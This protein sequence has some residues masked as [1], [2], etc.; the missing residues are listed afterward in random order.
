MYE[1]GIRVP[2]IARWPGTVRAG[3]TTD[4]VGAFWDVLDRLAAQGMEPVGS[5][6]AQLADHIR[7]ELVKW[8]KIV[9][10]SGAKVD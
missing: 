8:E 6:S 7:T 4:F 5:T 9:K 1:G 10:L 3:T 2:M